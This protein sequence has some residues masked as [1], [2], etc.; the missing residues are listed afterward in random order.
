MENLK[1]FELD[2]EKV[3][4]L[5]ENFAKF[6]RNYSIEVNM[7]LNDFKKSLTDELKMY[8]KRL[9]LSDKTNLWHLYRVILCGTKEGPPLVELFQTLGK[10]TILFRLENVI[11]LLKG[12]KIK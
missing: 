3:I 7:D 1:D 8:Q 2:N 11:K 4:Q 6:L 10:E 9:A 12:L 5:C